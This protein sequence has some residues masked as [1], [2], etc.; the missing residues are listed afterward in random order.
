MELEFC[1]LGGLDLMQE[2]HLAINGVA[3]NAFITTNTSAAAGA[4][5][6]SIC[7]LIVRK[8]VT[9]LGIASGIVVGLV[10]ITPGAGFVSPLS[11]ILIG[12]IGGAIC[13][14]S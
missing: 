8:K 10:A 7:E 2:A 12:G 4:L 6:W 11:S 9:S 1:G 3:L 14:F 13:F 5:A